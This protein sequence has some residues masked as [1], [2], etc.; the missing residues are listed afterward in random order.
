MLTLICAVF[1]A[2]KIF[3]TDQFVEDIDPELIAL[4]QM[5]T[6]MVLSW[7]NILVVKDFN[8]VMN[9]TSLQ[10]VIYLGL[11]STLIAFGI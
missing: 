7:L 8:F 2:L 5:G 4:I 11:V 3:S 10:P 6:A 9:M 1:F